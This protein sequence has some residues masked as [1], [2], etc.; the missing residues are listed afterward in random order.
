MERLSRPIRAAVAALREALANDGIRRLEIVWSLGIGADAALLVVLLVVVYNR[1]GA[2]ATGLL[3][4]VRMA[5][6]VAC[7][8]RSPSSER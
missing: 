1:E 7:C 3:G 6:A 8:S 4:A 5:P 2:V